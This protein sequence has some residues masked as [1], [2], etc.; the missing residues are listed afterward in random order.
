MKQLPEVFAVIVFSFFITENE[1]FR[2][3]LS[4]SH[5]NIETCCFVINTQFRTFENS[6]IKNFCNGVERYLYCNIKKYFIFS[7]KLEVF[8][9][10]LIPQFCVKHNALFFIYTFYTLCDVKR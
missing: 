4:L 9:E 10:L 5:Y 2:F 6:N 7:K 3:V 1:C 8:R